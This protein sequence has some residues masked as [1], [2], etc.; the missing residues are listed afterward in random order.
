[1]MMIYD[2][3]QVHVGYIYHLAYHLGV[4]VTKL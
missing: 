4:S 2:I 3:Y 1:M